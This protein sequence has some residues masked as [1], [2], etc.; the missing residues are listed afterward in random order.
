[1]HTLYNTIICGRF[2]LN[3]CVI[4]KP[5]L[6][7]IIINQSL[8]M[9]K[10]TLVPCFVGVPHKSHLTYIFSWDYRRLSYTYKTI[11]SQRSAF[12]FNIS[13]TEKDLNVKLQD[14]NASRWSS[15][16]DATKTITLLGRLV[17]SFTVHHPL[18]QKSL[19]QFLMNS[20]LLTL[21][22]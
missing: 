4:L 9:S 16:N 11:K 7:C 8:K 21:V 2:E 12:C 13:S 19:L 5:I 10:M 15:M 20:S 1:M 17:P 14:G 18:G 3:F 6:L 22:L